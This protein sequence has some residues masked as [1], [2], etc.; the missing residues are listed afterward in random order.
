VLNKTYW[1]FLDTLIYA[2]LGLL[3]IFLLIGVLLKT[4]IDKFFYSFFGTL[5]SLWNFLTAP[6]CKCKLKVKVKDEEVIEVDK[7][8]ENEIKKN[9]KGEDND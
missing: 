7:T 5:D 3:F 8:F 9:N 6:R 2:I 4:M 1:L